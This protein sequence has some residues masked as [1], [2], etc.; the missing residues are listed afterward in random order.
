MSRLDVLFATCAPGLE[1]L[2]HAEAKALRLAKVERQVGGVR[3]EGRAADVWRA[4][5]ELRTAIR[6]LRRLTRFASPDADHLYDG[7]REL[8]WE[9]WLSPGGSLVVDAQSN[10]SALDHTLFVQQRTKDAIVDR[11][12]ATRG[13]RPA[14]DR[15]D[16][17]LRVHVHLF[18][19]RATVS[20]DSSGESLHKRGWRVHQ[21]RAPLAETLA[22][23]VVEWS[24]WDRRAPFLDPFCGSGTLLVEAAHRAMGR[25]PG[26][27]RRFAFERWPEHDAP[28]W[29]RMR[30][31][32]EQRVRL[33]RKLRLVGSDLEPERV[34]EARANLVA[35]GCAEL[36]TLEVRD[37]RTLELRPGWNAWIVTNLPYGVRVGGG[38]GDEEQLVEAVRAFGARLREAGA[39]YSLTTLSGNPRLT[40]AL[41]LKP[42]LRIALRNGALPVELLNF[43]LR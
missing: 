21:G 43:E 41:A 29:A 35:A 34:E 5:L 18:R 33:P 23:A 19:D 10:E 2:L 24:G 31:E 38:E 27:S 11:L 7:V 4:N 8:P 40:K 12:K 28:A 22:A 17:D 3:F 42:S 1:P 32:A 15:E 14:V 16:A 36:A 26:L 9:R 6:V 39:G 30:N 25:A 13:E 37:A 20:V